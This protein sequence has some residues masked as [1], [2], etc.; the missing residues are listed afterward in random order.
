LDFVE[1]IRR[2]SD[3]LLALILSLLDLSK[4]ESG[5]T[6]LRKN[7]VVVGT[8]LAEVLSTLAPVAAKNG[9]ELRASASPDLPAVY[10]DAVRLRQIFL[11]PAENAIKFTPRGGTVAL[12]GELV[13]ETCTDEPGVVLVAPLRQRVEVRVADTGV[14]VPE[15]ERLRVFVPF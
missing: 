13:A 11:K 2:K 15:S 8:V 6:H 3:Q 5:T 12:T 9:V 1:T 10:G 7:E 14:G 4:L